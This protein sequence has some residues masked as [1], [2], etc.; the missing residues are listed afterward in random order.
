[1]QKSSNFACGL[2]AGGGTSFSGVS[3]CV[4]VPV[5]GV[6]SVAVVSVGLVGLLFKELKLT[7]FDPALAAALGFRPGVVHYGLMTA[8]ALTVVA[9]FD[10]VGPV[11]VVAFLVVPPAAAYLLTDRLAVML[12][13]SVLI[14]V[15]G[16]VGGVA[17]ALTLDTNIAGTAA[18]L[19]GAVE[20][21]QNYASQS[22][23]GSLLVVTAG[24]NFGASPGA[25][26]TAL[27]KVAGQPFIYGTAA[28]FWIVWIPSAKDPSKQAMN[29]WNNL[30]YFDESPNPNPVGHLA[31]T[32]VQS[33][34][35]SVAPGAYVFRPSFAP[36][37][38]SRNRSG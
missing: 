29:A 20:A 19:F 32:L 24:A 23:C 21:Q 37:S 31:G 17:I 16:A 27:N 22:G 14:A 33:A 25:M 15:A 10:A 1:M 12:G 34:T 4:P 8:V 18:C 3:G 28:P 38:A 11:L 13:L 26:G 36:A 2:P 9:A 5:V 7:T 6:V 30:P 35:L